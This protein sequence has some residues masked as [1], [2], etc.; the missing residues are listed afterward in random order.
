MG[1]CGGGGGKGGE[2]S[3]SESGVSIEEK[4][5]SVNLPRFIP[6]TLKTVSIV[7]ASVDST[8]RSNVKVPQGFYSFVYA[9][10]ENG[11]IVGMYYG[12][13]EQAEISIDVD[14]TAK[15]IVMSIP[16]D[17]AKYNLLIS[18]VFARIETS[19]LYPV[20]K[21]QVE[22]II[23][24][25]PSNLISEQHPEIWEMAV[26]I[27]KE[28]VQ[29]V[30]IQTLQRNRVIAASI[31]FLDPAYIED[32]QGSAVLI[33]NKRS[34]PYGIST[35]EAYTSSYIEYFGINKRPWWVPGKD[36]V[37]HLATLFGT[38]DIYVKYELG[39]SSYITCVAKQPYA[40]PVDFLGVY[41]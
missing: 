40:T 14:S 34:V 7:E 32:T 26:K 21:Q 30:S 1:S 36:W 4:T 25:D 41:A 6:E 10:D 39:A 16:V 13:P 29:Y 11:N 33:K 37:D 3:S 24:T 23:N 5:A 20:L 2:V 8:G 18:D 15:A 17:W 9:T 38:G 27:I 12:L 35:M 19:Q 28:I 22:N 31:E